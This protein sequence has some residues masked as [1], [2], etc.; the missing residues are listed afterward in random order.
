MS[1]RSTC[2]G[3]LACILGSLSGAL[4]AQAQQPCVATNMGFN[5]PLA[6]VLNWYNN[7]WRYVG[8]STLNFTCTAGMQS[9]CGACVKTHHFDGDGV[10]IGNPSYNSFFRPEPPDHDRPVDHRQ[11]LRRPARGL[12]PPPGQSSMPGARGHRR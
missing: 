7:A 8:T 11:N 3:I 12:E 6:G 9:R 2:W 4:Y 5:P 1:R 10:A